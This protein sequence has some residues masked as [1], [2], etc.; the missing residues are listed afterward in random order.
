[1]YGWDPTALCSGRF[2]LRDA[3]AGG[4]GRPFH[5]ERNGRHDARRAALQKFAVLTPG[6]DSTTAGPAGDRPPG[7]SFRRITNTLF[8]T[9]PT[10]GTFDVRFLIR[11]A[12]PLDDAILYFAR[13]K[14]TAVLDPAVPVMT[15]AATALLIPGQPCTYTITA[16]NAVISKTG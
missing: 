5:H 12:P 10:G 2:F 7:I 1:M 6:T 14:V 16:P 11:S 13:L 3:T 8:G 9:P 4:S 15:S